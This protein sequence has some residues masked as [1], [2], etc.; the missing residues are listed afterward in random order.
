MSGSS[1]LTVDLPRGMIT[2]YSAERPR[3]RLMSAVH[4]LSRQ[5]LIRWITWTSCYSM[6]L[7]GLNAC[8]WCY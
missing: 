7:I 5:A 6:V 2:P 4:S 8:A 1:L 3:I